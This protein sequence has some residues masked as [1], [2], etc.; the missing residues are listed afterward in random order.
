MIPFL[1][2]LVANSVERFKKKAIHN[3]ND[4]AA[5]TTER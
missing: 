2:E 1:A 4:A 5:T 3:L